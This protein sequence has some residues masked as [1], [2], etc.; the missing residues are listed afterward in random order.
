M[1]EAYLREEKFPN[2]WAI[3]KKLFYYYTMGKGE[4]K[5]R[6]IKTYTRDGTL[7]DFN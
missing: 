4:R 3:E 6:D 5:A 7:Q 1:S 2:D